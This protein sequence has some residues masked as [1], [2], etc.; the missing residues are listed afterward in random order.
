MSQDS[1]GRLEE[2]LGYQFKDRGLLAQALTHSSLKGEVGFSNE[3]MEFLGDAILGG[4]VSE[5][6]FR[7]FPDY[8]EGDLTQMRSA[9]VSRETL[10]RLGED[11]NLGDYID[12]AKGVARPASETTDADKVSSGG[13]PVSLVSNAVEAIIAAV[14]LDGGIRAARDFILRQTTPEVERACE[15]DRTRNFKSALQRVAQREMST[16]PVYRV[17][18][19]KGPDHGKFFEVTTLV[20]GKTYGTGR[21]RTKKAA[22][23]QAAEHTLIILGRDKMS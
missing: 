13:L 10:C 5:F 18:S 16:T 7:S 8:A 22:E 20:A 21:G 23:Q 12:V 14:Y 17:T 11:L 19:E 1:L 6:L 9:V 15:D 4:V 3:R 2:A